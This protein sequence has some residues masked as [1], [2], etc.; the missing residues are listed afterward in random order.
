MKH[1]EIV[2]TD[3][4]KPQQSLEAILQLEIEIAEKIAEA[5]DHA[6]QNIIS[7]QNNI[8]DHKNSIVEDAR[9]ER[10]RMFNEGVEIAQQSAKE[11]VETAK[12]QAEEFVKAGINYEKEATELVLQLIIGSEKREGR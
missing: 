10:D 11:R 9:V 7:T 8:T 4:L 1:K 2:V 12:Q 3:E 5:K 6:D